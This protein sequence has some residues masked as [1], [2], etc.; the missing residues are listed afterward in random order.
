MRYQ[1]STRHTVGE[2]P[3]GRGSL[4]YFL[5]TAAAELRV[6]VAHDHEAIGDLLHD[7]HDIRFHLAQ[8]PATVRA[9]APRRHGCLMN[10]RL[11]K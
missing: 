9:G 2:G 6:N 10:L 11:T 8:R 1:G 7:F 4:D 3:L 5:A